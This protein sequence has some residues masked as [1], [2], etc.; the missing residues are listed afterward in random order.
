MTCPANTREI[1]LPGIAKDENSV[2]GESQVNCK[3]QTT[4]QGIMNKTQRE[5][6]L[7]GKLMLSGIVRERIIIENHKKTTLQETARGNSTARKCKG[8]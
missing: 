5:K 6:V 4:S 1:V 2:A 8:K 7:H 3:K